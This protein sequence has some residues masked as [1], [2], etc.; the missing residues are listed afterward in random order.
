MCSIL[1]YS[2][3]KAELL[4]SPYDTCVVVITPDTYSNN[5]IVAVTGFVAYLVAG[6][7]I[8]ALGNKFIQDFGFIIASICGIALYWSSY[9]LTTLIITALFVCV[10]SISLTS[11]IG[12]SVNLFPT[13]LRTMIVSLSMTFGRQWVQ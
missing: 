12:T 8:N 11:A 5:I 7:L 1:E 4:Q 6:S 3:N 2:V 13:S 10:G 9:A